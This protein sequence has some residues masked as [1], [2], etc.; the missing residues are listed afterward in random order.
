ML[1]AQARWRTLAEFLPANVPAHVFEDDDMVA[2]LDI[3]EDVLAEKS[4]WVAVDSPEFADM[5]SEAREE[6]GDSVR[7]AMLSVVGGLLY[8]QMIM[9]DTPT[10]EQVK[11]Q[12]KTVNVRETIREEW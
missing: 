9:E 7:E 1:L 8:R 10:L 6:G 4:E 12:L 2:V 5:L 3:V 11:E